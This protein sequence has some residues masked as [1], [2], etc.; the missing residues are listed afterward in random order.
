M[1]FDNQADIIGQMPTM[2]AVNNPL[3]AD[4][5]NLA[6]TTKI[7][8]TTP[9]PYNNVRSYSLDDAPIGAN[10]GLNGTTYSGVFAASFPFM[11]PVTTTPAIANFIKLI[12]TNRVNSHLLSKIGLNF[13]PNDPTKGLFALGPTTGVGEEGLYLPDNWI[14]DSLNPH[15]GTS[16]WRDAIVSGGESLTTKINYGM[17]QLSLSLATNID[18][19]QLVDVL[20]APTIRLTNPVINLSEYLITFY[21]AHNSAAA[22]D[23]NLTSQ[24]T[25]SYLPAGPGYESFGA[26]FVGGVWIGTHLL[27]WFELCDGSQRDACSSPGD[28]LQFADAKAVL[29]QHFRTGDIYPWVSRIVFLRARKFRD[30][31]QFAVHHLE[32]HWSLRQ[33]WFDSRREQ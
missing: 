20:G 29:C 11:Q 12:P 4:L 7:N 13:D 6:M 3:A 8:D 1:S 26:Q 2:G 30:I 25:N 31:D 18:N 28:D 33:R 22:A 9:Y 14:F 17:K 16:S 15:D 10:D 21:V 32:Q 19:L 5:S 24:A 27:E 23:G